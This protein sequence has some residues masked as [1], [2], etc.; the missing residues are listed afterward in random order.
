MWSEAGDIDAYVWTETI[1]GLHNSMA[2]LT[3]R[4]FGDNKIYFGSHIGENVKK[5]DVWEVNNHYDIKVND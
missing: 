1:R 5:G 2:N 3:A 4:V